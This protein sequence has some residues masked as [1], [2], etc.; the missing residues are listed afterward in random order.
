RLL[1]LDLLAGHVQRLDVLNEYEGVRTFPVEACTLETGSLTQ[2]AAVRQGGFAERIA[3]RLVAPFPPAYFHRH[4]RA[5]LVRRPAAAADHC[6]ASHSSP[7]RRWI[8]RARIQ[9]AWRP[10]RSRGCRDR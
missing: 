9:Q 2:C 10:G 7:P 5:F 8:R 4:G 1:H 6:D 3:V